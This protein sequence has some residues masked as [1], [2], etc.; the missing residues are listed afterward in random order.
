LSKIRILYARKVFSLRKS[1]QRQDTFLK[2]KSLVD[3]IICL[4]TPEVFLAIGNFYY[5]FEQL[6]DE[7]VM[8]LIQ[9][10]K[11]NRTNKNI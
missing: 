5:E 8:Q 3:E 4:E 1:R 11:E 6:T 7:E 9:N 2:L 10:D